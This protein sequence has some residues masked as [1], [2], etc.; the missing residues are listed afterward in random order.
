LA[1]YKIKFK[2]IWYHKIT[3]IVKKLKV[4]G[5]YNAEK[6]DNNSNYYFYNR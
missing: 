5:R 1:L 2:E 4:F 6:R 3:N